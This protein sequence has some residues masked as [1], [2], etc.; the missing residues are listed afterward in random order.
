MY[1]VEAA[2]IVLQICKTLRD[3]VR[4]ARKHSEEFGLAVEITTISTGRLA[5]S[6]DVDSVSYK[7]A[8]TP[9]VHE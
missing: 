5:A 1:Q 3:A 2:G 9:A 7:L 8:S 4:A 6:V